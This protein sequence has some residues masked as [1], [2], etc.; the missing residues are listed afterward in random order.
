MVKPAENTPRRRLWLSTL[1]MLSSSRHNVV[2]YF[3]RF[4]RS[5][6]SN[7]N[8]FDAILLK[9]ALSKVLVPFYPMA[10]RFR[11]D[12]S[13]R[14]EID[15]NEEGVLFVVAETDSVLD[16]LGDFAP[17]PKLRALVPIVDYSGGISSYPFLLLQVT[18]Q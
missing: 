1:D 5:S 18:S 17:T 13:G 8:F 16:E 6:T 10:G 2:V 7:N 14:I 4:N 11:L 3:Y 9:E 15:C 12:D